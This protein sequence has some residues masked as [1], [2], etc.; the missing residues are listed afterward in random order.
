MLDVYSINEFG[1][2]QCS[3]SITFSSPRGVATVGIH[4]T[5]PS[6]DYI[7]INDTNCVNP[8]TQHIDNH[9][10]VDGLDHPALEVQH[11]DVSGMSDA[12]NTASTIQHINYL[13]LSDTIRLHILYA[14]LD[15]IKTVDAVRRVGD[16]MMNRVGATINSIRHTSLLRDL[17]RR[18]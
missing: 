11:V 1:D 16:V 17:R 15:N 18:L 10:I 12:I 6:A 5:T 4:A 8:I 13:L 3:S 9:C 2:T 7:G 14:I